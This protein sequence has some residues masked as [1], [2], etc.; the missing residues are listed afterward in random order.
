M[1]KINKFVLPIV[2]V[3]VLLSSCAPEDPTNKTLRDLL[4]KVS[5]VDQLPKINKG[6]ISGSVLENFKGEKPEVILKIIRSEDIFDLDANGKRKKGADGKELTIEKKGQVLQTIKLKDKYSF[7]SDSFLPGAVSIQAN[8]KPENIEASATVEI[9]K[10]SLVQPMIFGA[11]G[12]TNKIK[13]P[14][15]I[16]ISGKIVNPDGTPA[17]GAKVADVTGGFVS[18]STI[19]DSNGAFTLSEAPFQK[20]RSIEVSM[21]NVDTPDGRFASYS[22]L[23][24]ETENIGITITTA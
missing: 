3:S 10:V 9:G 1:K 15:I 2:T 19:T 22:V 7:V 21:G 18:I 8:K 12:D 16:N 20:P 17:V 4:T 24:D 13:L 5:T 6:V 14:T 11:L 23:P